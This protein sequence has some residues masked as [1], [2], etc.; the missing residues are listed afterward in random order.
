MLDPWINLYIFYNPG[1]T[2]STKHP[3]VVADVTGTTTAAA[4][5]AAAAEETANSTQIPN[6]NST[7][8]PVC[9]DY[10]YHPTCIKSECYTPAASAA[11]RCVANP[12]EQ[13]LIKP[14]TDGD[15]GGATLPTATS[16]ITWVWIV[17]VF[18]TLFSSPTELSRISDSGKCS[19]CQSTSK[20]LP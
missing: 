17:A 11:S 12:T 1:S 9:T 16:S 8:T 5:A 4:A 20:W 2:D 7:A 19:V 15:A 18:Y 10:H 3:S 6:L 13:Y 14:T